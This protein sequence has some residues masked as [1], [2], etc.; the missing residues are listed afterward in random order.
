MS[1]LITDILG[2]VAGGTLVQLAS[3]KLSEAAAAVAE[4]GKGASVTIVLKLSNNN[5]SLFIDGKVGSKV[6]EAP[7][8]RSIFF[9]DASG[10][11][12]R[13]DP[14]QLELPFQRNKVA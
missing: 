5:G 4:T 9:V 2:D 13:N 6:P 1:R 10:N 12:L 14:N 7:I 3:D 11:L 8:P